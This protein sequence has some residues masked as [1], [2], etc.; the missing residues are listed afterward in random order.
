MW[1]PSWIIAQKWEDVLALY[2]ERYNGGY[3]FS[4][5]EWYRNGI[6]IDGKGEHNSY[7]YE[8]PRLQF[9]TPYWAVLTRE[10]DGKTIRTCSCI[11]KSSAPPHASERIRLTLRSRENGRV[12]KIDTELSGEYLLYDVTGK[13]LGNGYFGEEYGS[14]DLV[15]NSSCAAGTYLVVFTAT[16]GT[17]EIKK[18]AIR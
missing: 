9:G 5:I 10:D 6:P 16:D 14:P 4:H 11:P 17:K 8:Q 1:Y 2:N 18:L 12:W 3:V 7:I 13:W 15:I